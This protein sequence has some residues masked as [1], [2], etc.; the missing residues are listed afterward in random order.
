MNV[1]I[2][3]DMQNDF[4]AGTLAVDDAQALIKRVTDKVASYP[5][6]I[7][8]TQDTHDI[9]YKQTQEG[10]KLPIIHCQKNTRGWEICD[11]LKPYVQEIFEKNIFGSLS[12]VDYLVQLNQGEQPIEEIELVG[13]CSDICVISNALL[14]KAAL[15]EVPVKVDSTLFQGSSPQSH[16]AALTIM[17]TCQIEVI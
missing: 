14:I 17:K 2:V 6:L 15:S 11:E 13:V 16:Q 3:V 8:F 7:I 4:L 1:L 12:L 9:N 10:Q 5:G